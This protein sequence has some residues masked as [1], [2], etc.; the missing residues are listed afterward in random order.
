M[1]LMQENVD[2]TPGARQ[3]NDKIFDQNMDA[4]TKN[5]VK[6]KTVGPQATNA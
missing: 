3:K 5:L 1:Q 2:F 4:K 6:A